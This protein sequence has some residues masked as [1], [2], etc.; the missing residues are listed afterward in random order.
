MSNLTVESRNGK[1]VVESTLVAQELGI[2]HKT[3]MENI[4]NHLTQIE[5]AFG[6]VSVVPK[7]FK[8]S[9]GNTST[10]KVAY[11]TEEQATFLMTL[12]R[13]TPEVI[14]AKIHLVKAFSK[15]KEAL[16]SVN[17]EL[18]QMLA[19]MSNQMNILT[20]RTEQLNKYEKGSVENPGCAEI[21][22]DDDDS[23]MTA[24]EF[25]TSRRISTELTNTISKRAS[26]IQR[27]ARQDEEIRKVGNRNIL[28]LRY[29]KQAAITTL[30]LQ[31]VR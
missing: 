8:T 27:G 7:E 11:L 4:N 12:S 28:K 13:N 14:Q 30:K 26:Q 1:L 21:L 18:L 23:E 16:S 22:L 19:N 3:L 20:A 5:F 17:P 9:Q 31:S 15:A 10:K 24:Y 6:A 2:E 25:V 29:L